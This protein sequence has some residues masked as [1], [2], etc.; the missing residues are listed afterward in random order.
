M[1][2]PRDLRGLSDRLRSLL[3][4]GD[5]ADRTRG[6]LGLSERFLDAGSG[7]LPLTG[8]RLTG[9][10]ERFLGVS[11]RF[12]AGLIEDLLTGARLG[13]SGDG[14]RRFTDRLGLG[15]RFRIGLSVDLFLERSGARFGL[16]D[17]VRRGVGDRFLD[18]SGS[19]LL[20]S[21]LTRGL[22]FRGSGVLALRSGTF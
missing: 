17:R 20:R 14:F 22:L 7:D 5:R 12:L 21:S 13:L 3:G 6:R 11:D 16:G 1:R 4:E 15:D 9:L 2:E 10:P 8:A 18:L 19:F